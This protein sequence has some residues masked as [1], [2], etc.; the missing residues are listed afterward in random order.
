MSVKVAEYKSRDSRD[1]RR[2]RRGA[3][4]EGMRTRVQGKVLQSLL[5]DS[6]VVEKKSATVVEEKCQARRL[7][8][9]SL[10]AGKTGPGSV[11]YSWR[12]RP[13]LLG[14]VL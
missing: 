1:V 10:P 12:V 2:A 8:V 7:L 9:Q 3:A 5:N 14:R 6:V 13:L 11:V 4:V